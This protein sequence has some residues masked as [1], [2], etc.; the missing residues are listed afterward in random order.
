M[1]RTRDRHERGMRGPVAL[2]NRHTGAAVPVRRH[3]S[4]AD[5]FTECV[6][7]AVELIERDCPEALTQVEIG[8]ADVPEREPR[9][10]G[11]RALLAAAAQAAVGEPTRVVVFRRP[12]EH[13]ADGRRDLRR[14]V[15]RTIVEQLSAV[16]GLSQETIDPTGLA[17]D[18]DE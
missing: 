2:P 14:L 6:T 13:R 9:W 4:A 7:D 12:L 11:D 1:A 8:I 18:T 15:Y 10:A 16:T 3:T 5:F 17:D